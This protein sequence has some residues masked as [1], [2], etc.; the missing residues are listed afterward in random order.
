M[1]MQ[2]PRWFQALL[3]IGVL[4]ARPGGAGAQDAVKSGGNFEVE[5]VK[6][7]AYDEGQDADPV[8]HKL[9]LYLPRGA[10][11]YPVLVFVHGGGWTKGSKDGFAN[12]GRLFAKN[13][14]GFV[15]VNYRLTPQ[16][17]HPVHAQD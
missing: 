3:V 17:Q 10:K 5:V 13:G 11:G 8:R 6:D 2:T 1:P 12:H 15:A 4:L 9:D 14:V 7:V 16:V